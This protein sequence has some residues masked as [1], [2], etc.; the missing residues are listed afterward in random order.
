MTTLTLARYGAEHLPNLLSADTLTTIRN[1]LAHLPSDRPGIRI[2]DASDLH[3]WLS[4]KGII[5]RRAARYLG[6]SARPVRTILFDKTTT[7]NW[8]LGWHQD[9]TIAVKARADC[10]GFGPWTIK[11]GIQ[12]VMP[13]QSLLDRM[14]TLRIHLDP[15]DEDNAPLLIAPGSHRLGLVP[16][17]D[18]A[19]TVA[20]CGI[21]AC[22][23]A[24]GDLWLYATPILHAS[25]A[26]R[27]PHRRR[28]LQI[29][30]SA[31][32]LPPPLEWLGV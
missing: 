1:S 30:Y 4:P 16:E 22:H 31:D 24:A 26:A 28:V 32:A 8:S 19:A 25:D 11:A 3:D 10:P 6:A 5:G 15:V 17:S 12:H 23:A 21:F 27:T 2:T 7:T 9:R 20:R 14:L 18:V 13:P 29:D